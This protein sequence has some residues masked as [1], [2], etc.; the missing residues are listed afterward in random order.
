MNKALRT[1]PAPVPASCAECAHLDTC[2]GW[3]DER[4]ERGCY[5]KC[6]GC[7]REP[8]DYTCPANPVLFAK[9]VDEVGGL[10]TLPDRLRPVLQ[11]NF[12]GYI[13]QIYHGFGRHRVL[14]ETYVSVPIHHIC[15]FNH[16][17]QLESKYASRQAMLDDF[18]LS[19]RTNI[20]IT[21]VAKD[22]WIEGLYER[23]KGILSALK[24]LDPVAVTV[25]NF[26]FVR[27]SPRTNS[28]W[29]Q[30]KGFRVIEEMNDAML[31][32]I[33]HL[34][35]Q[36][37]KDWGRLEE[38]FVLFPDCKYACM[39]FQTGLN[40]ED[41]AY[42]SREVYRHH[43]Q[44]FHKSAGGLIHPI[45]LA[46]YLEIGFL[47]EICP[48]FSVIDAN[49]FL[50]TV[51]YQVATPITGGKRRWRPANPVQAADLS[52]LLEA[53]IAVERDFLF[54]RHGLNSDGRPVDPYLLPAA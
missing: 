27:D 19:R 25:P 40:H 54:R 50:K 45:V 4:R 36:T 7:F 1:N 13:P 49:V 42:P 6:A 30:T 15:R 12:P 46:G 16:R 10:G 48:S 18:K 33:P 53:N 51:N 2:G 3:D 52:R 21:C 23:R 17:G 22:H 47:S 5:Q 24:L 38:L 31:P 44:A 29:N 26:S 28:I 39:E 8:C 20:I 34:Q 9:S 35:A 32:T 43:F 14:R 41:P 11:P 37:A